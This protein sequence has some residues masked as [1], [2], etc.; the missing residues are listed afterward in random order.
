M[1]QLTRKRALAVIFAAGYHEDQK[2][3]IRTYVENRISFHAANHAFIDGK[4]A[5]R[6]GLK[7]TCYECKPKSEAVAV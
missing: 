5:K 7:C 6:N 3:F 4:A 2:T 1:G